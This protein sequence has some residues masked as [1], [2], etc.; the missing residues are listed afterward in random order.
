LEEMP[1]FVSR[2][3]RGWRGAASPTGR[4]ARHGVL[5]AREVFL[6][7]QAVDAQDG[8]RVPRGCR[9]GRNPAPLSER[10]LHEAGN[11]P[12]RGVTARLARK[13][14]VRFQI[15]L[16]LVGARHHR[17]EV[18]HRHHDAHR[19][20]LA[21][22]TGELVDVE[23]GSR[24]DQSD[25]LFHDQPLDGREEFRVLRL[26]H[27]PESVREIESRREGIGVGRDDPPSNLRSNDLI[28]DRR[29]PP[30]PDTRPSCYRRPFSRRHHAAD[31]SGAHN[32]QIAY[33]PLEGTI[34]RTCKNKGRQTLCHGPIVGSRSTIVASRP[35]GPARLT[36]TLTNHRGCR[37][38]GCEADCGNYWKR[39][40]LWCR[41][42]LRGPER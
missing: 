23:A 11:L 7:D 38:K 22:V 17:V 15:E 10:R 18:A 42:R 8:T 1:S 41:R 6:D 13:G 2:R 30:P 25:P 20:E 37:F 26:R 29:R 9:N 34:V 3:T 35:N 4:R 33:L 12:A 28:E 27:H 24:E 39:S 5:L 21:L 31:S 16:P 19:L 36:A 32:T 14:A 40:C